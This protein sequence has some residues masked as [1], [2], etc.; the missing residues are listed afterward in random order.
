MSD[1]D[2]LSEY[3]EYDLFDQFCN[4]SPLRIIDWI[5]MGKVNVN[6]RDEDHGDSILMWA[7]RHRV[8]KLI[9]FLVRKGCEL[10]RRSNEEGETAL[11]ICSDNA[12]LFQLLRE[13]GAKTSMEIGEEEEDDEYDDE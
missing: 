8:D 6:A 7:C 5:K 10:N 12:E 2:T 9:R 4:G 13:H 11:V 3:D 1:S